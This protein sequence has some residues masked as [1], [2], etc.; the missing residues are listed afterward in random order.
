MESQLPVGVDVGRHAYR[1]GITDP[2]SSVP[3]VFD[4][5]HSET[6]SR[7]LCRRVEEAVADCWYYDRFD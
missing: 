4:I 3:E 1:V 2:D 5:S 6:C 7:E